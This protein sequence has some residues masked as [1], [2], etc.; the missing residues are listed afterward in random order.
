MEWV[1]TGNPISTSRLE[2]DGVLN[3]VFPT[4]GLDAGLEELL[5]E[6]TDKSAP[7]LQLAKRAQYEAYYSPYPEAMASIQSLYLREL[8]TL[9]DA[10]EG[11]KAAREGRQP[12]WKHC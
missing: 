3:R 4:G 6:I 12:V 8:M 5:A 11:P 1:L 10:R 7:V 9:Q 2:H